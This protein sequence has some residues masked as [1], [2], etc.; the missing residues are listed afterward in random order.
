MWKDSDGPD[1]DEDTSVGGHLTFGL[2]HSKDGELVVE[3]EGEDD[4]I[5]DEADG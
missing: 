2:M 5:E 1:E 4:N 3:Y